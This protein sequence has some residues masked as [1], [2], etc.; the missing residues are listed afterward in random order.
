MPP[1][2]GHRLVI[3]T[4]LDQADKVHLVVCRQIEDPIPA[5]QRTAWLQHLYPEAAV[6]ILDVTWPV[7]DAAGWAKGTL[8][9]V[10]GRPGAVFTSEEYGHR[11]AELLECVHVLVDQA[12]KAVPVSASQIRK[13]PEK[14]RQYL[15]SLVWRYFSDRPIS[16]K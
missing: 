3:Q 10:G 2:H 14:Y 5:E 11:L 16:A 9:T 8:Q 6:N 4:A 15:D 12:R 13:D 1:H 7:T